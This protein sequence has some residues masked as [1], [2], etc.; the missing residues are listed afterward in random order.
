[1]KKILFFFFVLVHGDILLAQNSPDSLKKDSLANADDPSQFFTRI[2]VFNELQYYDKSDIYLNQTVVRTI[3]KV[4]KRFTTRLDI[5]LVYNSFN[6]PSI[7]KQSVLGDITFRLLG[8]RFI[9][10]PISAVT[11]CIEISMNTAET[12]IVGTGKNLLI[13]VVS[14]ALLAPKKKM[15]FALVF[16]Q[17]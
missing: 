4:G 17:A 3:L 13:P 6:S 1:M 16:Q 2:E 9:E 15:I 8:F 5:Q 14:Y 10:T 12:P 7:H 11:A